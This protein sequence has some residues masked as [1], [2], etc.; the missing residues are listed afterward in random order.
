MYIEGALMSKS[1]N[2]AYKYTVY[3][4]TKMQAK[5]AVDYAV[6]FASYAR[7]TAMYVLSAHLMQ[8]IP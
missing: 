5:F 2:I 4:Y 8:S 7:F 6:V 3:S 1:R